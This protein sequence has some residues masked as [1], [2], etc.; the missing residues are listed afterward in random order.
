MNVRKIYRRFACAVLITMCCS[1]GAARGQVLS[2][3]APNPDYTP[4]HAWYDV[5]QSLGIWED[6]NSNPGWNDEILVDV[7]DTATSTGSERGSTYGT[8]V[9]TWAEWGGD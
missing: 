8:N 1:G 3:G 9:E 6:H 7:R 5:N 4:L 2:E